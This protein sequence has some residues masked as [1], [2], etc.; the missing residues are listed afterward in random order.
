MRHGESQANQKNLIISD[1]NVGC[2]L[3]GLTAKGREQARQAAADSLLDR[4]TVIIASDFL[5]TKETA[6][7]VQDALRCKPPVFEKGLRERFFGKL[8]GD[9]GTRYTEVWDKD[10]LDS[11]QTLYGAESPKHLALRLARTMEKIEAQYQGQTILLVSHGDPLRFLQLTM[12]K[13]PLTQHLQVALFKP[14]EIRAL[15]DLPKA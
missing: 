13:R 6:K 5:R 12:A 1:P 2:R 8:E 11:V 7:T 14:A 3:Y 4:N 10:S 15:D 9:S